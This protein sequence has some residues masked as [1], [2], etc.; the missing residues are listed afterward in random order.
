MAL[1]EDAG[2]FD[3]ARAQANATRIAAAMAENKP[4]DGAL[5]ASVDQSFHVLSLFLVALLVG[6]A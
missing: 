5:A 1:D 6:S 3:P 2:G 4:M